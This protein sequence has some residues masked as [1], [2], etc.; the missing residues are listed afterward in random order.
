MRRALIANDVYPYSSEEGKSGDIMAY[1]AADDF[2]L[3]LGPLYTRY[4][5]AAAVRLSGGSLC[6]NKSCSPDH[7]IQ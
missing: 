3:A 7:V 6:R 4:W 1:R 5:R 2:W